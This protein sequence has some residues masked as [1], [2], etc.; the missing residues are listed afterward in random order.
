VNKSQTA[1]VTPN[2]K[3]LLEIFE[4]LVLSSTDIT[5]L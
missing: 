1:S 5:L 4:L 2:T 3:A